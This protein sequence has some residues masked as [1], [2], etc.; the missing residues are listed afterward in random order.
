MKRATRTLLVLAAVTAAACADEGPVSGPGT[1]TATLAGPN[2]AEGAALIVILDEAIEE[3][4]PLGGTEVYSRV[5]AST[6][7]VVLIN[8]GGGELTKRPALYQRKPILDHLP[9][10]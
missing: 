4:T 6:T 9:A 10:G 7:Q 5:G 2:G 8:Q 3:I 1:M